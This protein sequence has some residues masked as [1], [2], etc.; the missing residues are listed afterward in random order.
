MKK[1]IFILL[2]GFAFVGC[3]NYHNDCLKWF[4]NIKEGTTIT[5]VKE[6][7]PD[8]ITINWENPDTLEENYLR[9]YI[10]EINGSKDLLNMDYFIEFKNGKFRGAFTHK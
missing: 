6:S 1:G 9:Y 7:Q 3:H 10:E 4:N 5:D 8:F 2:V